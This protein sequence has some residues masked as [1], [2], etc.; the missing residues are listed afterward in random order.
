MPILNTGNTTAFFSD[1]V[2]PRVVASIKFD[3]DVSCMK[4]I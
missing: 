1:E 2:A 4:G 3:Q